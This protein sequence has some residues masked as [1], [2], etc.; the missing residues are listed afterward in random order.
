M[1]RASSR[2]GT[3]S[4]GG[5]PHLVRSS[6]FSCPFGNAQFDLV[7][8]FGRSSAATYWPDAPA[9]VARILKPGG[10]AIFDFVNHFSLY[11][12]LGQPLRFAS[13]ARRFVAR[14]LRAHSDPNVS[15]MYHLGRIGIQEF[16]DRFD[17]EIEASR[18]G[19][20]HPPALGGYWD[21]GRRLERGVPGPLRPLVGR[22]LIVK[23]RRR[24]D[25]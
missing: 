14:N 8:S 20:C 22:S 9:E 16:F 15:K 2:S 4:D 17:L 25:G 24:P 10:V 5:S 7:T 21:L 6:V 23:F 12:I 19:V 18:F 1:F 13:V 11:Y 3:W